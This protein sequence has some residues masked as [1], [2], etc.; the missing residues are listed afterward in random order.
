MKIYIGDNTFG[1]FDLKAKYI[2]AGAGVELVD[3]LQKAEGVIA[4]TELYNA[5]VLSSA[6]KLKVISRMGVGY[7]NV[8][9]D[10]CDENG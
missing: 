2:L 10:Y 8:D 9:L 4:G 5:D 1:T 7:D 3:Y 6:I